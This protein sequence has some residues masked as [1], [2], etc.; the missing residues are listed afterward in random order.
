MEIKCF[1]ISVTNGARAD[2]ICQTETLT[3]ILRG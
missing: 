3:I 2:A 1:N